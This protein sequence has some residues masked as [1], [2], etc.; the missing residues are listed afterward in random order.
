MVKPYFHEKTKRFG[1]IDWLV[2]IIDILTS[3]VAETV[4]YEAKQ[5]FTASG[6]PENYI[7]IE[8]PILSADI[9]M[10]NARKWNIRAL[11]NAAQNYIDHN[12]D[13]FDRVV[14]DLTSK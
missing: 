9:R 13:V 3:S 8:P 14:L 5:I 10:D 12:S 2:P 7:R 4:G 1:Y 11:K 6:V